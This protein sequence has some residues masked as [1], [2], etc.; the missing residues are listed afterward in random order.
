LAFVFNVPP[1]VEPAGQ[2]LPVLRGARRP[3]R[4]RT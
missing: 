4:D 2:Y 1:P 3:V